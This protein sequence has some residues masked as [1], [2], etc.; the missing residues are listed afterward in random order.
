MTPELA[1][2]L[3]KNMV[4]LAVM[5]AAPLLLAG[6]VVGLMISLFQAV[7]SIQE[8]TLTFVPK[9]LAVLAVLI[10]SLPWMLRKVSEFAIQLIQKMPDMVK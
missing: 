3:I 9:A 7:T 1:I 6:M 2:E 8:Q 5:M 4:M 10:V